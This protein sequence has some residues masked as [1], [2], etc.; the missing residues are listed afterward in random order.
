MAKTY[1]G[2]FSDVAT[3]DVYTAA[4]HNL[5]LE[6]LN[7]H[8][9]PPMCS[10]YRTAAL[11]HTATGTYQVY[12]YDTELYDTDSMWDA[13]SPTRITLNT[14]GV[15]DVKFVVSLGNTTG[16]IAGAIYK[17]GGAYQFL[18]LD[19]GQATA[20]YKSGSTNVVSTGSTYIEA[21]FYQASGGSLNYN[22]GLTQS[23]FSATWIGQA[24]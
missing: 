12:T 10:V 20:N 15:Y 24:S 16:L 2:P 9:V 17:D 3:G 18:F 4:A 11:S 7:N 8:R 6:N 5:V 22:V 23:L 1:N 21:Y 13:G 14:A 19:A